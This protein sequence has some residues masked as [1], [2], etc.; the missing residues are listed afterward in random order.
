MSLRYNENFNKLNIKTINLKEKLNLIE[1]LL[2]IKERY[3]KIQVDGE[4]YL[5][6]PEYITYEDN[7]IEIG[8]IHLSFHR[9]DKKRKFNE[10]LAVERQSE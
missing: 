8:K 3:D 9:D 7:K 10:K 6:E 1:Y 4:N 2:M 5:I